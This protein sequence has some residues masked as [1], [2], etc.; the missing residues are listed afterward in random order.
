[1]WSQLNATSASCVQAILCLSL[2]SSWD[3]KHPPPN[4][5]N[6]CIFSRDEVSPSSQAALELL[7]LWSTQLDLPKCCDYRCEPPHLALGIN[8]KKNSINS[9]ITL[10]LKNKNSINLQRFKI[11]HWLFSTKLGHKQRKGIK[12]YNNILFFILYQN[13]P[14]KNTYVHLNSVF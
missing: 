11:L 4:L 9:G 12:R 7:T 6:F 8:L 3:Y 1:M 2:P 14:I 13:C 5:A 10:R